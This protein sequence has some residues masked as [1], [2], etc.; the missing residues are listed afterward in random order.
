MS[1]E[2][3]KKAL[4]ISSSFKSKFTFAAIFHRFVKLTSPE[5]TMVWIMLFFWGDEVEMFVFDVTPK[6]WDKFNFHGI[7]NKISCSGWRA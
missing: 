4:V 7:S 2:R 3:V 1:L 5:A 6:T